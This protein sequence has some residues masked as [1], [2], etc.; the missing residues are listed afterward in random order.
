MYT[1]SAKC[2]DSK[3]IFSHVEAPEVEEEEE[4]DDE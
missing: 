1:N 4:E 2:W 3:T